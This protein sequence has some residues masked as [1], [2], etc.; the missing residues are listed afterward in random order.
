MCMHACTHTHAHVHIIAGVWRFKGNFRKSFLSF[1]H[2]DP[3]HETKAWQQAPLPTNLP[4]F[5]PAAKEEIKS[6][7]IGEKEFKSCCSL[8]RSVRASLVLPRG[9]P[10]SESA[11]G[12]QSSVPVPIPHSLNE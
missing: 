8:T 5:F 1:H 2:L 7:A 12:K 9:A 11:P 6:L 3:G 4:L 10:S